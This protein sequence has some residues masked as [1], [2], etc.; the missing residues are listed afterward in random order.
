[1]ARKLLIA[2]GGGH[3][4][5]RTKRFTPR[6]SHSSG[7]SSEAPSPDMRLPETSNNFAKPLP[8]VAVLVIIFMLL[9][10]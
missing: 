4:A 6:W 10:C 1:M 7:S 2:R 9:I 5:G 3:R 8:V